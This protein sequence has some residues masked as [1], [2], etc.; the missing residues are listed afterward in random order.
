MIFIPVS[1]FLRRKYATKKKALI[2]KDIFSLNVKVKTAA[3]LAF[4]NIS[5]EYT[6]QGFGEMRRPVIFIST[7]IFMR[8]KKTC[9]KNILSYIRIK[10]RDFYRT[11]AMACRKFF[12]NSYKLLGYG[13]L[14]DIF[15]VLF[16]RF[17]RAWNT[18][19]DIPVFKIPL[20]YM[21]ISKPNLQ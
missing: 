6:R 11:L 8:D 20:T 15:C 17:Q 2:I 12:E 10:K 19:T 5:Y 7:S 1:I 4:S 3:F 21:K 14:A 16:C 9:S 18:Y 13:L